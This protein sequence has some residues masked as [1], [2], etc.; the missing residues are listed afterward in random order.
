MGLYTTKL[1]S[2]L[3]ALPFRF[4]TSLV[5]NH[6]GDSTPNITD[7]FDRTFGPV[8]TVIVDHE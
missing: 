3:S 1:V 2:S 8:R 5:S 4:L 6:H 7:G